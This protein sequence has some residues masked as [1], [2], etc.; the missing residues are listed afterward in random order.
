[1]R[2]ILT[3]PARI[4]RR[5][6]FIAKLI[7]Y[8]LL[9]AAAITCLTIALR[10]EYLNFELDGAIQR[11]LAQEP[12]SKWRLGF[13]YLYAKREAEARIRARDEVPLD[14]PLSMAQS[15]E[16]REFAWRNPQPNRHDQLGLLLR[17]WT[18]WQIFVA[19]LLAVVA[20]VCAIHAQTKLRTCFFIF[21]MLAGI[22][23]A[24]LAFYRD[25]PGALGW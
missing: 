7:G 10:I 22:A 17:T 20:F 14:A 16:A 23:G 3:L 24:F 12:H 21:V 15:K 5:P 1:M 9:L 6:R 13:G 2:P 25:Y 11:K 4:Q 8:L 19:P 18:P